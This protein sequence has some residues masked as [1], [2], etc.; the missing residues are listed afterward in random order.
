MPLGNEVY[1][2]RF[3]AYSKVGRDLGVK[4]FLPRR[5]CDGGSCAIRVIR[6]I[7][8]RTA[9]AAFWPFLD[10]S[11][12]RKGQARLPCRDCLFLGGSAVYFANL[13]K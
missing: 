6:R 8:G 12:P 10:D 13:A 7:W 11:P 9:L 3:T 5:N 4:S 1:G 2:R